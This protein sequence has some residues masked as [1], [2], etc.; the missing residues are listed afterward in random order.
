MCVHRSHV[1][2][3]LTRT[4]QK[5]LVWGSIDANLTGLTYTWWEREKV[6]DQLKVFRRVRFVSVEGPALSH[7]FS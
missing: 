1:I 7:C 3:T 2:Q 4:C 5:D 6:A